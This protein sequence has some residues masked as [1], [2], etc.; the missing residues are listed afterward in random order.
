MPYCVTVNILWQVKGIMSQNMDLMMQRGEKLEHGLEKAG[1]LAVKMHVLFTLIH[2]LCSLWATYYCRQ[3]GG[4]MG[5][6]GTHFPEK[7][8]FNH[9]SWNQMF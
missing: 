1:D 6:G 8:N 2:A 7:N 4:A 9:R 3:G 5:W